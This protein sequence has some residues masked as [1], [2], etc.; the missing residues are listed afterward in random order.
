MS[1]LYRS[2]RDKKVTGLLGGL[3]QTLGMDSTLLRVI[4]IIVT[5]FTGVPIFLYFLAALVVPKEPFPP[6]DPY[7]PGPGMG[8]YHGG[9]FSTPQQGFDSQGYG[10]PRDNR[11]NSNRFDRGFGAPK[12]DHL[13]SMM[14][15][16]EK[17]ALKKENE[18]LRKKLSKYEKGEL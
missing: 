5:F 3:S 4:F 1:K 13:D 7:A 11:Y 2:R 18:E 14:E 8:G 10:T 17:K 6:Y 15:D 12:E 9:G 16:I